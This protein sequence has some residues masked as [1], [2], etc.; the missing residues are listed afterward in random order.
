MAQVTAVGIGHVEQVVDEV[1]H[2]HEHA[3]DLK[4]EAEI[5]GYLQELQA[6]EKESEPRW[7]LLSRFPNYLTDDGISPPTLTWV[8]GEIPDD[9]SAEV[10]ALRQQISAHEAAQRTYDAAQAGL[11]RAQQ[12]L[13][14]ANAELDA[15]LTAAQGVQEVPAG[16]EDSARA[17]LD[18]ARRQRTELQAAARDAQRALGTAEQA[19][20]AAIE[21]HRRAMRAIED[22]EAELARRRAELKDLAFNNALLKAVRAARPVL[23]D[24]LWNLVLAAV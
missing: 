23:A 20:A 16:A 10:T 7:R 17:A 18:D 5:L 3:R 15:A 4:A 24:K 12:E 11:A 14:A 9:A 19:R 13:Q 21:A 1:G 22:G 2:E 8:G 6:I